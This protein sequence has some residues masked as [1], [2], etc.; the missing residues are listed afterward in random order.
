MNNNKVSKQGSI[1]KF[2]AGAM[3]VTVP[4]LLAQDVEAKSV[5]PEKKVQAKAAP[6]EKQKQDKGPTAEQLYK[7]SCVTD[8]LPDKRAVAIDA[9]TGEVLVDHGK[10]ALGPFASL[11]KV[12]SLGVVQDL[13]DH[14]KLS[15]DDEIKITSDVLGIPNM[16]W[17]AQMR[18]GKSSKELWGNKDYF[19]GWKVSDL[20]QLA[21]MK[22]YN[23][24]MVALA[25]EA[26]RRA[27]VVDKNEKPEAVETK[28]AQRVS[29][30]FAKHGIKIKM[31]NSTGLPA[32]K[33]GDQ[34][35]EASLLGIANLMRYIGNNHPK[36]AEVLG[37]KTAKIKSKQITNSNP[38]FGLDAKGAES[39]APN[40]SQ[41]TVNYGK[42]GYKCSVGFAL[43]ASIEKAGEGGIIAVTTGALNKEDR[44]RQYLGVV[45]E[46]FKVKAERREDLKLQSVPVKSVQPAS[47]PEDGVH[48]DAPGHG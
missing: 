13:I 6:A 16:Q 35:E 27:G 30:F 8:T 22:S 24:A 34:E 40:P 46:A 47:A 42:T 33:R 43:A 21:G 41:Y 31:L 5:P 2:F 1:V 25:L 23:D 48:Q 4:A 38:L 26:E 32:K 28:F 29:D 14:G 10:D 44:L 39:L 37:Q 17:T 20:M 15:P 7:R 12:A 11:G 19:A 9:K 45:E 18:T 3:V 36:L